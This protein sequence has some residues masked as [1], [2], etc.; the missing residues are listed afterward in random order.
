M[1]ALV[2]FLV[3]VGAGSATANSIEL[4]YDDFDDGTLGTN[5]G[6]AAGAMS[7]GGL[8]DPDINF[9]TQSHDGAYALAITYDFP[10]GQWVGYWSFFNADESGYDVS[11]YNTLEMW[12][13]GA[14]GGEKFKVEVTDIYYDPGNYDATKNHKRAISITSI[15]SFS[16]GLSPSWQLLSIP[17]SM[18]TEGNSEVD[19]T[20]LKQVNLIFD[21]APTSSTIFVDTIK[22]TAGT[23]EVKVSPSTQTV[24]LGADFTVSI[25]VTPAAD[26][27][28]A[29]VTLRFNEEVVSAKSAIDGGLLGGSSF[30]Y[31]EI[32]NENGRV[33]LLGTTLGGTTVSSPGT[34]ATITFHADALGDSN[35]TLENVMVVTVENGGVMEVSSTVINGTLNVITAPDWDINFD[36]SVNL[37]DLAE[38]GLY[39]GETGSPGWIRAD[40]DKD[41]D[42]DLADLSIVAYHFGE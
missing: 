1:S 10:S 12:V 27:S 35:L 42:V 32:D 24:A 22:F 30:F 36:G 20:K 41:G 3:V 39:F 17:L 18:F 11:G 37:L 4:I 6:G 26:I 15:P 34:F 31:S 8:W 5:L 9:T 21:Q 38:V 25:Y 19:N 2:A 23:T 16:G 14:S 40:V 33:L 13:R 7:P 29:Q 28:G